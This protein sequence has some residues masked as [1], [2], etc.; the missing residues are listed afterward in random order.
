MNAAAV[1]LAAKSSVTKLTH[2][3]DMFAQR[4][5]SEALD[6]QPAALA[7]SAQKAMPEARLGRLTGTATHLV[8]SSLD[9]KRPV[10]QA[11]I[12]KT[13]DRLVQEG[14]IPASLGASID[15]ES[16]LAFFASRL[17]ALVQDQRHTVWQDWPFTF[18]LPADEGAPRAE[19]G[20]QT[21]EE[22]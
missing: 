9:L 10:T 12:E 17:G 4:D 11:V 22:G 14:A 20:G 15:I 2:Q 19:D 6:R 1:Q 18:G 8:L 13:R 3:D 21:T 16:I 7:A 5:Y